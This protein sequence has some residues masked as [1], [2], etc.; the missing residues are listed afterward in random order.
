MATIRAWRIG[1]SLIVT[2]IAWK[3][4]CT[5]ILY[6]FSPQC[7]YNKA[8]FF[9][10]LPCFKATS[11]ELNYASD[12]LYSLIRNISLQISI[13][14]KEKLHE[15]NWNCSRNYETQF[16]VQLHEEGK[17]NFFILI[18]ISSLVH[19]IQY[20]FSCIRFCKF[21]IRIYVVQIGLTAPVKFVNTLSN[22]A[23]I[24]ILKKLVLYFNDL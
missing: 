20:T 1:S 9:S 12:I 7:Y 4:A 16:E 23:N 22:K 18:T 6:L 14:L 5:V 15:E 8:Y 17:S 13:C 10:R 19:Y 21:L 2:C 24:V 11:V 3:L